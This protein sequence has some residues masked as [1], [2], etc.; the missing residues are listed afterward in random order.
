MHRTLQPWIKVPTHNQPLY[1]HYK[2][3]EVIF[4][5]F[6]GKKISWRYIS[7][8]LRGVKDFK[9]KLFYHKFYEKRHNNKKELEIMNWQESLKWVVFIIWKYFSTQLT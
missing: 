4:A 9:I 6:K 2:G 7:D 5:E 1:C 3:L 8:C